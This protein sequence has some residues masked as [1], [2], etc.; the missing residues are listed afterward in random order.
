[1]GPFLAHRYNLNKL[2]RG[3]LSDAISQISR[4]YSFRQEDF[5]NVFPYIS[6]WKQRD[7]RLGSFLAPEWDHFWPQSGTIFG[8]RVII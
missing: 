1:M 2:G 3:P 7:P 8:P 6:Q 4:P 5:F